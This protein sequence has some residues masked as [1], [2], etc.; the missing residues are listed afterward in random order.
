VATKF[1]PAVL[2]AAALAVLGSATGARAGPM[3]HTI[4]IHFG[5]DEPSGSFGSTLLS[6]DLAGVP[7]VSPGVP[8]ARTAN[9]NNTAGQSG[10]VGPGG[11]VR[12]D[13]GIA[14]TTGT[15]LTWNSSN[16]WSSTGRGEENNN[17]PAGSAD[18]RL[19]TGYLDNNPGMATTIT[20]SNLPPDF[21]LYDVYLYFLGGVG[22]GRFG[23]YTVNGVTQHHVGGDNSLNG[24]L[25]VQ[26][27]GD[28]SL[29]N[30][31]LFHNVSGST[32]AITVATD[33][34][35]FRAPINAV[36]LVLLP[37][38]GPGA[39]PEPTSLALFGLGAAGLLAY[40]RRRASA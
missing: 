32:V 26:A 24:P 23:D 1:L 8:G 36:E 5:A 10:T 11:L 6:T 40:R 9:W 34:A 27:I 12:D 18:R 2:T 35:G 22:T 39:I 14:T 7:G 31:L 25:Y 33:D 19:T 15:S 38:P 3:T 28:N 30:Y 21:A 16:T 17:F 13:F 37:T 29:G 4:A 20:I